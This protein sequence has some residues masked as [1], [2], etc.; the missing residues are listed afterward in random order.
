[1]HFNM[2]MLRTTTMENMRS[3]MPTPVSRL[4]TNGSFA[5]VD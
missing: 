2:K 3:Q 5:N 1:M 4:T